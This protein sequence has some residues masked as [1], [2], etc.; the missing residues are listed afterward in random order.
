[1]SAGPHGVAQEE[2]AAQGRASLSVLSL[3]ELHR[4]CMQH[5]AACPTVMT[6]QLPLQPQPLRQGAGP[7]CRE[8]GAR[9]FS[10]DWWWLPPRRARSFEGRCGAPLCHL[11]DYQLLIDTNALEAANLARAAA[12]VVRGRVRTGA[13]NAASCDHQA[14]V[15]RLPTSL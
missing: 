1:M 11:V 12:Q 9:V 2:G 15:K 13:A 6:L 3:A 7:S 8:D 14:A 10:G 5:A 4:C